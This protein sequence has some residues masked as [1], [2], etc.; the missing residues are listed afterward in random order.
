M[1]MDNPQ[2]VEINITELCN[3]T[4]SFCPRA[5]GYP[6]LNLNM[7]V[8]TA[9]EIAKQC[10]GFTKYIHLVGRGEPLLNPFFIDIVKVFAKDFSL[11]IMT[12]GDHLHKYIEELDSI[13][14]LNSDLHKITYCLYDDDEQYRQA[15]EKY[16]QY[17]DI[18]LYKTYDTGNNLYDE[19]LRKK[20]WLDNRAGYFF[21]KTLTAPC[22]IPTNRVYIDYNGDVNLCCHDWKYKSVYGNILENTIQD[23][24]TNKMKDIKISLAKGDRTCTKECSECNVTYDPLQ[25]IYSDYLENQK[26]RLE[27]LDV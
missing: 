8:E 26:L 1:A 19:T 4:C 7:T 11:R 16:S 15:K 18:K 12:N 2:L 3:R 9:T 27:S 6:N 10:I 14:D 20:Q 17:K 21:E 22:H 13:L 25:L 5:A 23:I 24:W